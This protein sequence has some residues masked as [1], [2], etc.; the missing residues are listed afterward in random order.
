M[1][2][3]IHA[4][5]AD[6]ALKARHRAMWALGDYPTVATEVIGGPGRVL[7]EAC[8]VGAG[9]RV[10]D[11]AAG[12]GNADI[13]PALAGA[14]VVAGDLTP[15]LLKV[16]RAQ[17]EERGA[18]LEWRQA[19]AEALPFAGGEFDTVLSCVGGHVRPAQPGQRR[20]VG[21][22]LPL[23]RNHRP[24]QLDLEG[25]VGQLFATMK[26]YAPPPPP[27]GDQE[28]IGT[29]GDGDGTEGNSGRRDT[30]FHCIGPVRQ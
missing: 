20:R 28:E 5:E 25:F 9:E 18:E 17:A 24:A 14:S 26:P 16:G 23:R 2:D 10:L 13:P 19:E 4:V 8:G 29:C 3:V 1:T 27:S 11:V 21:P 6:R 30:G 22:R 7:V 12:S 15:E